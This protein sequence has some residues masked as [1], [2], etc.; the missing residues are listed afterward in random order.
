MKELGHLDRARAAF[1]K[2]IDINSKSA[3]AYLNLADSKKFVPGDPHLAAMQKLAVEP[4]GLSDAD[5]VQLD[6]A[7]G[8]AY[9]DLKDHRRS[10]EHLLAANAGKRAMISYDEQAA[11]MEFDRI[12]RTFTRELIA[13][14]SGRGDASPRPIFILGMP[15][16]GTTLVEQILASHPMVH[17]AGELETLSEIALVLRGPDGRTISYPEFVPTLDGSALMGIGARYLAAVNERAPKG[18]RVTDKMPAN[19]YFVGL[20]HLALPNAKIIHTIRNPVDTCLSCFSKLFTKG[21]N[22]TYDLGELGRYYK[23][24]EQLMA[25]WRHVLPPGRILDVR[26]EDVVEDLE[27]QARRILF[28]CGLGW[29]DRCL[30]F[31]ETD[32]PVRTASAWQVRQPIYGSAVGR[33]RDYEEFLDPLLAALDVHLPALRG[34]G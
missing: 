3:S 25:H 8:K 10:F 32:R 33:W 17:G 24:Y 12:E 26:Y 1:L 11:L 19:Y 4:E 27:M 22:H 7:L 29:D 23:R 13:T 34:R 16:S 18:E 30:S 21:Q 31:H 14:K 5:R 20:I 2:T 28:H 9:A 6:F 15:R